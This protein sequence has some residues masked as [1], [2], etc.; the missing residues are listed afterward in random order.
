MKMINF[1][2]ACSSHVRE[3]IYATN[4]SAFE[5]SDR[6]GNLILLDD[7]VT[8]LNSLRKSSKKGR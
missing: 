4:P 3:E 6:A 8:I 5:K 1:V 7:H 2:L